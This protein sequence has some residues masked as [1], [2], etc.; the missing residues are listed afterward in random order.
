MA[1]QGRP[2]AEGRMQLPGKPHAEAA[3]SMLHGIDIERLVMLHHLG[4]E[5]PEWW[6]KLASGDRSWADDLESFA[7]ARLKFRGD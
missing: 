1:A 4:W 5:P 3:M 6:K 7:Q 2:R